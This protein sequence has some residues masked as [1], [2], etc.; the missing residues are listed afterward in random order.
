M[1]LIIG[2]SLGAWLATRSTAS[3]TSDRLV[4]VSKTTLSQSLST[5]GT[6]E[7]ASTST[8]AFGAQGEVTA[9]KVTVGQHVTGGQ[10]LATMSSPSLQAQVDEAEATLAQDQAR[11][12]GDQ[13]S[14]ASS[15]QVAADQASVSADQSQLDSANSALSGTTMVA[16]A[17]GIVTAVGY[18]T[19]QQLAGAGGGGGGSGGGSGGGGGGDSGGGG[20]SGSPGQ[21]ITVVSSNDVVDASVD[22]SVVS[23]IKTGDQAGII[24]EGGGAPVNG[25]VGSIGLVANTSS[26]VATFPVVIDV[27]GTPPGL[28]A[29]ASAS[30][31][32]VYK[33]VQNALV[34]PTAAINPG[35]GGQSTVQ[36]MTNGQQ[37]TRNVTTGLTTGGLTQVTS[38]LSAGDTVVVNIVTI[39][40]GV[41]GNQGPPKGRVFVGPGGG[42][43]FNQGPG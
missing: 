22:A 15:A 8:L 20:S 16:P 40:P 31:S 3:T 4:A 41:S 14:G 27:T 7:P 10:V 9:V 33:Q 25:T 38:G 32:I 37:V 1:V 24:P 29:G 18:T 34:V 39:S 21:S 17:S 2:G 6:I 42:V 43:Q 36:V 30:V 35:P 11:L 13:A 12:S 28:Y 26:G 5:T 19:G 23:E